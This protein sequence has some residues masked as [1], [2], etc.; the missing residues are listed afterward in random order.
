MAGF[1]EKIA[2]VKQTFG[3]DNEAAWLQR[4]AGQEGVGGERREA[5]GKAI[6]RSQSRIRVAVGSSIDVEF[7]ARRGPPILASFARSG[8]STPPQRAVIQSEAVEGSLHSC[9]CPSC[10]MEFSRNRQ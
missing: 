9:W 10:V 5:N 3:I 7:S 1:V 4:D 2:G 6:F 8:I